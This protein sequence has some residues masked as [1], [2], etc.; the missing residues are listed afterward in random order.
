VRG[1]KGSQDR[2]PGLNNRRNEK[3][4]KYEALEKAVWQEHTED[5]GYE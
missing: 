4:E 3:G 5:N 1:R 2:G